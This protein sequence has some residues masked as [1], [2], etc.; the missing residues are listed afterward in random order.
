MDDLTAEMVPLPESTS[1]ELVVVVPLEATAGDKL[2]RVRTAARVTSAPFSVRVL[3]D[4]P[5]L[6]GARPAVLQRDQ[7]A[8]LVGDYLRS[9]GWAGN[10]VAV[11][12]GDQAVVG[13]VA[14]GEVTF[15]V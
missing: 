15:H 9:P 5:I 4:K 3:E 12:I 13:T 6:I 10:E 2:L 7:D 11:L 8:V 14:N 1:S